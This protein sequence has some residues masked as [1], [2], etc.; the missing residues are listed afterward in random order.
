MPEVGAPRSFHVSADRDVLLSRETFQSFGSLA[1]VA[2]WYQA[3][4]IAI[5][6]RTIIDGV[7]V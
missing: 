1:E 6:P 4:N 2:A 7:M 5:P 3:G